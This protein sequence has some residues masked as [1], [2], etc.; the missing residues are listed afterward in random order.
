MSRAWQSRRATKPIQLFSTNAPRQHRSTTSCRSWNKKE[1]LITNHW[2]TLPVVVT[3][4][5]LLGAGS[6]R[7]AQTVLVRRSRAS[8]WSQSCRLPSKPPNSKLTADLHNN[9]TSAPQESPVIPRPPSK[10][11]VCP[12]THRAAP[13]RAS[14]TERGEVHSLACGRR[15]KSTKLLLHSD[16]LGK[17]RISLEASRSKRS[18][19]GIVSPLPPSPPTT[20]DLKVL[21]TT[22]CG[23]TVPSSKAGSKA[24]NKLD[25]NSVLAEPH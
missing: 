24:W 21:K 16:H 10:W 1:E 9:K 15:R 6:G 13:A 7:S 5:A 11:M 4:S 23:F 12:T 8:W 17:F 20:S 19:T 2:C 3:G 14:V 22:A 18:T 25:A